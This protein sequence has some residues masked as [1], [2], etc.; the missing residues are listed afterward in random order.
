MSQPVKGLLFDALAHH[1]A[2]DAAEA[3]QGYLGVLTLEPR[4]SDALHLLGV[5]RYQQGRLDEAR[6][7]IERA[8][9]AAPD[10]GSYWSN[11]GNVLRRGGQLD[12]AVAAYRQ[13]LEL[14]P[15]H[16]DAANNLARAYAESGRAELALEMLERLV[17]RDPEHPQALNNL[18]MLQKAAGRVDEALASFVRALELDDE[19]GDAWCNLGDALTTLGRVEEAAAALTRA[20]EARPTDARIRSNL[21]AVLAQLGDLTGATGQLVAA[22]TLAPGDA[23]LALRLGGVYQSRGRL[24]DAQVEYRMALELAPGDADAWNNLGTIHRLRGEVDQALECFDHALRVRTGFAEAYFNRGSLLA[25]SRL[26]IGAEESLRRAVELKPD[27]IPARERLFRVLRRLGKLDQSHE[28]LHEWLALRPEDPL[29]LHMR[30]ASGWSGHV[31]DRC[32]V[33]YVRAEFDRSAAAFDDRLVRDLGYRLPELIPERLAGLLPQALSGSLRVLDGGCGT[34]LCGPG[35]R[36]WAERL[37]GVDL[38]PRM[39]ERAGERSVYD[40]LQCIDLIL[41]LREHPRE[42]DLFCAADVFIYFGD[43]REPLAALARSLRPGGMVVFSV[44]QDKQTDGFRLRDSGRYGH[45]LDYV[46]NTLEQAGFEGISS[47]AVMVRRESALPVWG[48]LLF[49][50]GPSGDSAR[51]GMEIGEPDGVAIAIAEKAHDPE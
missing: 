44:E 5:L 16:A 25:D 49:A 23:N 14:E 10:A 20:V 4:H 24:D 3:E 41:Y 12:E 47:E 37:V 8:I 9:A 19:Y 33:E 29:A 1:Q 27:L 51:D 31:P 39:L 38:S 13:A 26:F 17:E 43:L 15:G 48:Y 7:L 45:A 18:G 32:S 22:K 42:F 2:G 34:G 46:V 6:E 50:R 30:D 11:L 21:A 35:L 40:E 36:P 28:V